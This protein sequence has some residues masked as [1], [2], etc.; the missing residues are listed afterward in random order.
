MEMLLCVLFLH[1]VSSLQ[2]HHVTHC[3]GVLWSLHL[4]RQHMLKHSEETSHKNNGAVL[5]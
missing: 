3:S 5:C 2:D 1:V 4:T